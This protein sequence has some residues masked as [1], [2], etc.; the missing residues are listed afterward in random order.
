MNCRAHRFLS[1]S[2]GASVPTNRDLGP[3]L[4]DPYMFNVF[5]KELQRTKKEG[6]RNKQLKNRRATKGLALFKE[7]LLSLAW[8]GNPIIKREHGLHFAEPSKEND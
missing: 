3:K 8:N 4:K 2:G 7:H 1:F 5:D 6:L